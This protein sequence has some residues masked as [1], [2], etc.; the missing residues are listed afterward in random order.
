MSTIHVRRT[1]S[2][3][4]EEFEGEDLGISVALIPANLE[5]MDIGC[6]HNPLETHF[7]NGPIKGTNIFIPLDMVLGGK[8]NIG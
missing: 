1:F 6:R 8:K 2:D 7:M 4:E 3:D 5:G